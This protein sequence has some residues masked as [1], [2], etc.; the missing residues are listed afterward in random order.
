MQTSA[1][2]FLSSTLLRTEISYEYSYVFQIYEFLIR[3]TV[4]FASFVFLLSRNQHERRKACECIYI[5]VYS[6][7]IDKEKKEKPIESIESTM[8][9]K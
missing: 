5:T 3:T 4:K 7:N 9:E 2:S 6:E 1:L 8:K